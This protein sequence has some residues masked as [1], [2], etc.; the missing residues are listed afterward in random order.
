MRPTRIHIARLLSFV[1]ALQILNMSVF[2]Q[3][4]D[5]IDIHAESIGEINEINS[6]VEY[7]A[8]IVLQNENALPEYHQDNIE[9]K[10]L[11][12][13]KHVPIKLITFSDLVTVVPVPIAR[14]TYQH[15][16]N[17]SRLCFFVKEINPPPPKA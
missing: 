17:D 15:P 7:V 14:Y 11:Q 12:A 5:P 8:E 2:M 1:V 9:H 16:I 3:D 4:F 6:V 13:H 10:D